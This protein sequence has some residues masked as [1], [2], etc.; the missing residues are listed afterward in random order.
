MWAFADA[1]AAEPGIEAVDDQLTSDE[2][3]QQVRDG[4]LEGFVTP[5]PGGPTGIAGVEVVVAGVDVRIEEPIVRG[6]ADAMARARG[7][8]PVRARRRR[9]GRCYRVDISGGTR[10]S[11]ISFSAPALITVFAFL[12]TFMLTSAWRSCGNARP[13]R[14]TGS[15]PPRSREPTCWSGTCWGSSDSR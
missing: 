14:S 12:F 6:A 15:S 1:F 8:P 3:A 5:L 4:E 11:T 10:P 9:R 2:G 13:G 7:V